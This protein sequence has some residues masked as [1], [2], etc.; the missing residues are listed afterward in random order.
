MGKDGDSLTDIICKIHSFFWD[1]KDGETIIRNEFYTED[2]IDSIC[3]FF[4]MKPENLTYDTKLIL[5]DKLE[6]E[7]CRQVGE[8][9]AGRQ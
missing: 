6:K 1:K 9:K 8:I 3:K 7:I 5:V 4:S 2:E